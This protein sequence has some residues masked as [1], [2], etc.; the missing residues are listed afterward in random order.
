MNV[1]DIKNLWKEDMNQ[2]ERRVRVNEEKIAAIEF[3]KAKTGFDKLL[4]ISIAGKNMALVYAALSLVLIFLVKDSMSYIVMLVLAST[5]M[6]FSYFQH[7]V[8]KPVDFGKLSILEL[9]KEIAK[10]RVHTAKTAYYNMGIVLFWLS[11]AG[12][13]FVK[14]RSG[15]DIFL[16]PEG[17]GSLLIKILV[18][19]VVMILLTK[20][21]YGSY[22]T[23]LKKY[24][25]DLDVLR[26]YDSN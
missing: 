25:T 6:V 1:D 13:S 11:A 2:L 4:K 15:Y 17:T 19:F 20:L 9:Q 8:L 14:W 16:N 10:F 3:N 5:A 12:L 22:D 23:K 7:G 21:I 24:E 18:L 26:T